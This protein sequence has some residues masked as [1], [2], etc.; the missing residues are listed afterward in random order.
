MSGKESV[1]HLLV[2]FLIQ[3]IS[4]PAWKYTIQNHLLHL[5]SAKQR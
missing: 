4:E 2:V 1:K 5:K 3:L